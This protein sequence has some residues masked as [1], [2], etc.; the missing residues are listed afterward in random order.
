MRGENRT[1]LAPRAWPTR[2]TR[3]QAGG[4]ERAVPLHGRQSHGAAR[5]IS[6]SSVLAG[7]HRL[8]CEKRNPAIG[9]ERTPPSVENGRR[10]RC[11][12]VTLEKRS[13]ACGC[14]GTPRRFM[15]DR[16]NASALATCLNSSK[17][18]M[19]ATR[20]AQAGPHRSG[21]ENRRADAQAGKAPGRA[22]APQQEGTGDM[23]T[24]SIKCF[25]MNGGRAT[26]LRS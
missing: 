26:R 6:A 23:K 22:E 3:L 9:N 12:A 20:A 13:G 5:T 19:S 18:I 8:T 17:S 25:R 11:H 1:A 2:D 10:S 14:N 16:R 15:F 7:W 21:R 4:M 24:N